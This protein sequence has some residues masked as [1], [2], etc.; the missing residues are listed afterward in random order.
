MK[1]RTKVSLVIRGAIV[2]MLGGTL[3]LM[4]VALDRGR[5]VSRELPLSGPGWVAVE[6]DFS[7]VE[8]PPVRLLDGAE[9]PVEL[10]LE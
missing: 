1:T 8:S 7:R 5:E 10:R 3:V 9:V 6:A 2:G 4:T